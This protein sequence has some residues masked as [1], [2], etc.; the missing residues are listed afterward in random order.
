VVGLGRC[1]GSVGGSCGS[2]VEVVA[3][4]R[5]CGSVGGNGGSVRECGDPVGECGGSVGPVLAQQL[6]S[7]IDTRLQ[8]QQSR[9]RILLPSHSPE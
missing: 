2:I 7:L 6:R 9:V 5:C 4:G 1:G 8:A 3:L